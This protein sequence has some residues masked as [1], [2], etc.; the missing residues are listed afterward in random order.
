MEQIRLQAVLDRYSRRISIDTLTV[1]EQELQREFRA[2]NSKVSARYLYADTEEGAWE[3]KRRIR[4]GETFE[5]LARSVFDDPGLANN[6]GYLGSF[7][8]GEMEPAFDEIAFSIP[9]GEVSDPF[10]MNIGFGILK[11]ETR[12][13]QPLASEADYGTV[14]TRLERAV[15]ARKV[16]HLIKEQAREIT[17]EKAPHFHEAALT[18]LWEHWGALGHMNVTEAPLPENHAGDKLVSFDGGNWT[19]NDALRRLE[20]T[21]DRQRGRVKNRDDVKDVITGLIVRE[22][23]LRR[24]E[25]AGLS[26]DPDVELQVA[27]AFQRYRLKTWQEGIEESVGKLPWAEGVLRNAYEKDRSLYAIPPRVNVAEILVRTRQ[28]ADDVVKRLRGGE[29]F[30]ALAQKLSIRLWA[31]ERGGEL[32]FGE[33][34]DFGVLG[35]KFFAASPGQIIGPEFVDPYYGVFTILERRDGRAKSFE[36]ARDDII[37]TLAVSRKQEALQNTINRLRSGADIRI[38]EDALAR[39]VIEHQSKGQAS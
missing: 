39:V 1:S 2:Y 7:G 34:A 19:L 29:S 23:M 37:R 16:L 38:N 10:P 26:N 14:K 25:D 15:R 3:L 28:E 9:V 17:R 33:K 27:A 31:A 12:V 13:V 5:A 20:R 35:E 18:L 4:S 11:V 22:E 36:E 30:S 24:A 32:G 6:G 8:W 21:S